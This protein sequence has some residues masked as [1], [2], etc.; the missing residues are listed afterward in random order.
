MFFAH[1][2]VVT[3]RD[4]IQDA[5][6]A[7]KVEHKAALREHGSTV[8]HA[9]RCQIGFKSFESSV[10]SADYSVDRHSSAQGARQQ[11]QSSRHAAEG[12]GEGSFTTDS[13]YHEH[14]TVAEPVETAAYSD[15]EDTRTTWSFSVGI[16]AGQTTSSP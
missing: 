6:R 2:S 3:H 7:F 12:M 4:A 1:G 9:M 13:H 5:L 10:S 8:G 14:N 16:F 11:N 15:G